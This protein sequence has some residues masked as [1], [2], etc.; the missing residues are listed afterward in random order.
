MSCRFK[1]GDKVWVV[2]PV[3]LMDEYEGKVGE[4]VS[5]PFES[6]HFPSWYYFD[7]KFK[8]GCVQTAHD[9]VDVLE[10]VTEEEPNYKITPNVYCPYEGAKEEPEGFTSKEDL[11]GFFSLEGF[12]K[13]ANDHITIREWGT[14]DDPVNSPT[15]YGQGNIEAIEYIE[16]FLTKEEYIG[17]LRGNIAKYLHRWRFKGKPVE[18]LKKAQWYLNRL[19]EKVEVSDGE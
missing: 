6:I 13:S 4:I 3:I 11:V 7:I 1:K 17:Y 2:K 15:H 12:T 9:R 18:D 16:D 5:E 10:L 19:I 14:R 8:D